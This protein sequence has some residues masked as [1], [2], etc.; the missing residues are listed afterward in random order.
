MSLRQLVFGFD[1]LAAILRI[2]NELSFAATA[3]FAAHQAQ[4]LHASLTSIFAP[5][6]I[7]RLAFD[8]S[9]PFVFA[10]VPVGAFLLDCQPLL[11]D[12][13]QPALHGT[14]RLGMQA[15]LFNQ[16]PL[17]FGQFLRA[18]AQLILQSQPG[19]FE[20][21]LFFLALAQRPP[22]LGEALLHFENLF[23][24]VAQLVGFLAL[25]DAKL[26]ELAALLLQGGFLLPQALFDFANLQHGRFER[27]LALLELPLLCPAGAVV[28]FEAARNWSAS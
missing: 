24:L 20:R 5:G 4:P 21:R 1:L 2:G 16:L 12:F 14:S 28:F 3:E 17:P 10:L 19:L 23:G 25:L 8:V 18:A 27:G 15:S 9:Q 6:Q 11:F 13:G 26:F 22:V 7:A